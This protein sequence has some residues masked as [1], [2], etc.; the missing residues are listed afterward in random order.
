[1]LDSAIEI[2]NPA[3]AGGD[4]NRPEATDNVFLLHIW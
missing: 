1:M 2:G 3:H 4:G